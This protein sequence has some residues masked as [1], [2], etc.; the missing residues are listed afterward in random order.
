MSNAMNDFDEIGKKL[1]EIRKS[2]KI[3]Q[4]ELGNLLGKSLSTI[5]KY[6]SGEIEIPLNTIL[7]VCDFFDISI[8]EII[9]SRE[10]IEIQKL[11][12][13][14]LIGELKIRGYTIS[15]IF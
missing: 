3:T 8:N 11:G 14:D 7:K 6:E 13:E 2:K 9:E 5:Q 10:K 4:T 12:D 15:K 1:K